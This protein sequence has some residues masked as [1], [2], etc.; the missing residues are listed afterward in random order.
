MPIT[1]AGSGGLGQSPIKTPQPKFGGASSNL[2]DIGKFTIDITK[3]AESVTKGAE[4]V[5]GL[6][7]GVGKAAVSVI[8]N[9]PILGLVTKPVIGAVGSVFDATL[10]KGVTAISDSVIGETLSKGV[11]TAAEIA[12]APVGAGLKLLT[13]PGEFVAKRI[14]AART[15]NTLEAKND[16]VTALFGN[17]PDS[18]KNQYNSG[19]TIDEIAE[20][21]VG[22]FGVGPAQQGAFSTNAFANLAWTI[23]LD[24]VNL[25][26]I[27]KPFTIAAKAAKLDGVASGA[28]RAAANGLRA[29]AKAAKAAG[30]GELS[31][32][33][34][35]QAVD[36]EADAV[37]VEKYAWAGKMYKNTWGKVTNGWSKL[38]G[39][40]ISRHL[41]QETFRVIGTNEA[42][43]FLDDA[44]SEIGK[45]QVD[46]A[47]GN[48]ALTAANANKAAVVDVVVNAQRNVA[49]SSAQ[50][51][52]KTIYT[53]IKAGTKGDD[54]L[55][56][57]YGDDLT[58]GDFLKSAGYRDSDAIALIGRVEGDFIDA[59]KAFFTQDA[60]KSTIGELTDVLQKID[61]KARPD[62]YVNAGAALGKSNLQFAVDSGI[63]LM[64]RSKVVLQRYADSAELGVPYLA[65]MLQHGFRMSE[66]AATK[67]ATA[68]FAKH[69]GD[70]RKLLN[71]L[72]LGRMTSFGRS[73]REVA[74]LRAAQSIEVAKLAKASAGRETL[75][76]KTYFKGLG[77]E[78]A[79]ASAKLYDT[80]AQ[81]TAKRQ[82]ITVEQWYFDNTYGIS[83]LS[84]PDAA[85]SIVD[86][87][88]AKSSAAK[89][90]FANAVTSEEILEASRVL[91]PTKRM[92]EAG[93][94]G[95]LPVQVIDTP[96]GKLALPGGEAA[97][98]SDAPYN[99][100]DEVIIASQPNS[101]ID[102]IPGA[103]R[104]QIHKK[105]TASKAI[106]MQN[107]IEVV[108]RVAF[109]VMSPRRTLSSN[110]ALYQVLRMRSQEELS[111]FAS[112]WGDRLRV[113]GTAES[114]NQLGLEIASSFGFDKSITGMVS[115][116]TD[117]SRIMLFA[118]ENPEF[119][120]L[121]PGETMTQFGERLTLINGVGLKV[122][123]FAA[124]MMDTVA[125]TAGAIDSQMSV[126]LFNWADE[127]GVLGK[128][129]ADLRKADPEVAARYL[130]GYE[131]KGKR[132]KGMIEVL[133]DEKAGRTTTGQNAS[134]VAVSVGPKGIT[135]ANVT[136]TI[137]D[138]VSQI[139]DYVKGS[140]TPQVS[141]L[142]GSIFEV[143]LKYLD[144]MALDASKNARTSL[145]GKAYPG[146]EALSGAQK[147]WFFW[148][149]ARRQIEPHFWLAKG[150]D[151]MAKPDPDD[152]RRA[153]A[154]I[155]NAG[156]TRRSQSFSGVNPE[157][158]AEFLEKRGDDVLGATRFDRK[159]RSAIELFKNADVTTAIH[160]IGHVAR[161]QMDVQDRRVMQAI[162]GIND[163]WTV[164]AEERFAKDFTEYLYS[165]K[166]PVR[167]LNDLFAKIRQWMVELWDKVSGDKTVNIH[168]EA[169]GVF[170]RI[171][172]HNTASDIPDAETWSRLTLI[173]DRSLTMQARDRV[174]QTVNQL[175]GEG[176]GS[177][178]LRPVEDAKAPLLQSIEDG[179]IKEG[180][181]ATFNP[182][183]DTKR[184]IGQDKVFQ[185]SP[186][187]TR[188]VSFT[189]ADRQ[190][191]LVD[192][193]FQR[194]VLAK[195]LEDNEDL[196]ALDN[197]YIGLYDNTDTG[198]YFIDVSKS[199]D[200]AQDAIEA[201]V[202]A[203]QESAF[204][205]GSP[206]G[207][208]IFLD[209]PLGRV[210]AQAAN[211]KVIRHAGELPGLDSIS[212]A[213]P[214]EKALEAA[215]RPIANDLIN[216][217]DDVATIFYNKGASALDVIEW[218]RNHPEIAVRELTETEARLLPDAFKLK[219]ADIARGGYRYAIA[220][221][222]GVI[223]RTA[224]VVDGFGR[225][226]I[227]TNA[228]PFVDMLDTVA[229]N[230][231]DEL[232]GGFSK[233]P[234][235]LNRFQDL[236]TYQYGSDVIRNAYIERFT[237]GI[238]KKAKIS[239][240]D[241]LT[242]MA[243]V[244]NL[245]SRKQTTVRGL[246]FERDQVETIFRDVLGDVE[247]FKYI[248]SNDP[249]TDLFEA[250]RG[251]LSVV[252]LAPAVSGRAK[253]WKPVLGA[254]TDRA[255]PLF[256][257][258]KGN[259]I[260]RQ[261]LEPI[262]TRLMKLVFDI[263]SDIA[264]D[265]LGGR[266][267]TLI[268]RVT[269]DPRGAQREIAESVF[270]DQE[271]NAVATLI[272]VNEAPELAEQVGRVAKARE[273]I[274]NGKW[275]V[276][277]PE[278]YKTIGRDM[279][280][281]EFAV[282]KFTDLLAKAAPDAWTH[283]SEGGVLSGRQVMAMIL[284][285]AMVA[286]S[287]EALTRALK[288][289]ER[290]TIGLWERA[291]SETGM[292]ANKARE[293]AA[294]TYGVFTDAMIR[295][296]RTA[297]RYQYFSAYRSWF[298]RSINHPFLGV[299]PY[300]YMTQK[301]IP[302]MLRAMFM[303]KIGGYVRPGFGY[304]NYMRIQEFLAVDANTDRSFMT[305]IAELRP[306]WYAL[307][308]MIPAT[309]QNM[310]FALPSFVRQGI[311]RP[312]AEGQPID[313]EQLSKVPGMIGETVVRGT[314]LG[315]AGAFLG[316]AG[317]FGE[318]VQKELEDI[319]GQVNKFLP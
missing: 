22:Q 76:A 46:E 123:I 182:I 98:A 91:K 285:D 42:A 17:A 37:L 203:G 281:S 214:D 297:D 140:G 129:V 186:Y 5:V 225:E 48:A 244:N 177:E 246:W 185:V 168:P 212:K 16:L 38:T 173:S 95:Q 193:K 69:A 195:F 81:A 4:G 238:M 135:T 39:G 243:K 208:M 211:E 103:M 31:K 101:V 255:Y 318:G 198:T 190:R 82:G 56:I 26:P 148:D 90:A 19:Q 303:P 291:L 312:A 260:F 18:V 282:E 172:S 183:R 127:S 267:S 237:T 12:F 119:F 15:L 199:Y 45:T 102:S 245:A 92:V 2:A 107:P 197:H 298:E 100:I 178:I 270:I 125:A 132:T 236:M 34:L 154:A 58:L 273:L 319:Q 287:P 85:V 41:A 166:A 3:P 35:A 89:A 115:Q 1:G 25:I 153:L 274:K 235:L 239:Q 137:K 317:A 60:V 126:I 79:A 86:E 164:E 196:L 210:G 277:N 289:G 159:G 171:L 278:E 254:I 306:A 64:Q 266:P 130:D 49:Q 32:R 55:A 96:A 232:A 152:V 230:E 111:A 310:G 77:P 262:E 84:D 27:S 61:V 78:R 249:L 280:A 120:K 215:L 295:G 231:I 72:E 192:K 202:R 160:E 241:A 43:S 138:A 141:K 226:R 299:Y 162:Y 51:I 66:E 36:R 201:G 248:E 311:L 169:R 315:Q 313:F 209:T 20:S 252:G 271:K 292:P 284:E 194:Q 104:V 223:E 113:K 286:S 279:M 44:A 234:T 14:A 181:G 124:E 70:P 263:R 205:L 170:D 108:N 57:K 294:A 251:D 52:V 220:P 144:D 247:F 308:I 147:Q 179:L 62:F 88:Y 73:M 33:L 256:R 206:K 143:M 145:R 240:R 264:D 21:C 110:A 290:S 224:V 93:L 105:M 207:T 117:A 259:P 158:M 161:R 233:R 261:L 8:E 227:T 97:L 83:K 200:S 24:P 176:D 309:P 118:S 157:I 128:L 6:A 131:N 112:T 109:A 217:Y 184:E 288:T 53:A 151:N 59:P 307:N 258:G 302:W 133:A 272:A 218:V 28:I 122:G 204:G 219:Q 114:D 265:F 275:A 221:K 74:E 150:V 23:L 293:I 156:G 47:L 68:Q 180:D 9:L 300:S 188:E 191:F 296:T 257:F 29:E 10:G 301:A 187:K 65:R 121:K 80:M 99:I 174:L 75:V 242:I 276:L 216:R 283:L 229:I 253:V 116:V 7:Q 316:A 163:E 71:V 13:A 94:G 134:G 67:L 50:N 63:D 222:G 314:A 149:V 142:E 40:S 175:L 304:I 268:R 11:N 165:G 189:G 269:T 305:T 139:P 167:E 54:L 213:A 30:N 106:D 228:N 155:A 136:Q 250:A 87:L 146:V